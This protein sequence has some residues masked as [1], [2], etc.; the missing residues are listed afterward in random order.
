MNWQS[1][2]CDIDELTGP[3]QHHAE[4]TECENYMPL[5]M[6][7]RVVKSL[8]DCLQ[9]AVCFCSMRQVL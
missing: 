4:C 8:Y 1:M 9:V 3:F 7:T 5:K 2:L 6:R